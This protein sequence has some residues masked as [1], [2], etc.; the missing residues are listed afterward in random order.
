MR[1]VDD[2]QRR[3]RLGHRVEHLGLGQLL[4]REEEELHLPGAQGVEG[5]G[6]VPVRQAAVRL[7]RRHVPAAAEQAGDLVALQRDERADDDGRAVEQQ[8]GTW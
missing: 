7:H 8:G 3:L 6:A 2:E 5:G 4:R 1:L